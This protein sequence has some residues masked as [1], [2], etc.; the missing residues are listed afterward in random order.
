MAK[1]GTV[2]ADEAWSDAA[3]AANV[4]AD[5]SVGPIVPPNPVSVTALF[6]LVVPTPRLML[7]QTTP[8]MRLIP[9]TPVFRDPL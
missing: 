9:T 1:T 7:V 3:W 5:A 2:W 8:L 4:W 6:A